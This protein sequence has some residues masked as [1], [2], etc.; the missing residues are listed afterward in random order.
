MQRTSTKLSPYLWDR[1]TL[2][3]IFT[4]LSRHA[5]LANKQLI[6]EFVTSTLELERSVGVIM[7]ICIVIF[8]T[9]NIRVPRDEV[10]SLSGDRRLQNC[11]IQ[12]YYLH[13]SE[14]FEP[15]RKIHG[16]VH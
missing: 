6:N 16:I 9:P 12:L 5:Y 11:Y 3:E 7:Q 10:Q 1:S 14:T 4:T 8:L 13:G 2:I 15:R